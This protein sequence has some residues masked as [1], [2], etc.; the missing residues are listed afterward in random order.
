MILLPVI[1]IAPPGDPQP[2]RL[3]AHNCGD[4]DWI[5]FT[6]ANAIAAFVAELPFGAQQCQSQIATIGAATRLAAEQQGFRV[7]ITPDKYVAESLVAAFAAEDLNGRR[8]LIPS[9]AVTRDIVAAELR[10]RG[11]QVEAVEA[12]HNV[13]PIEAPERARAIFHEP[14]PDWVTFASSSAV[15]NLVKLAGI[16]ALSRVKIA[17]IGPITSETASKHGLTVATEAAVHTIPSL[18]DAVASFKTSP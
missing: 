1:G 9:A 18:V 10:K 12:Y 17:T 5:I 14:Y 16:G 15:E 3:A 4:F 6:S 13:I 2:L 11:A 7:S 8:I